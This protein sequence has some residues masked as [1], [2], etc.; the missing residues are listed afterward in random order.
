M[1]GLVKWA[2][3]GG[4][5]IAVSSPAQ[6]QS[7]ADRVSAV[8]E[9]TAEFHFAVRAGVC[10]N[11]DEGVSIGRTRQIGRFEAG[12]DGWYCEPGPVRV[13]LRVE[14]GVVR[15]IR[16]TVGP[17]RRLARD[18][19]AT[20]LGVV[21]AAAAATYFL[22]LAR[23]A[24]SHVSDRAITP[25]VLADS[26][27]PWRELLAVARDTATRSHGTRSSA[28]FWLSR[29][30]DAKMSGHPNDFTAPDDYALSDDN[31]AR[32]SAVFAL[33]QLRNHEGI[34]PL[35]QVART[36]RD[37]VVRRQALFWLGQSGD[38][39][40]LELFEEVLSSN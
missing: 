10:G 36:N 25:A 24:D 14:N 23:T 8:R 32:K 13:W 11:G 6:A 26:V 27:Y 38:T 16:T 30:V 35:V 5:V 39:R 18:P 33:S 29:F 34:L 12:D 15:D 40:A 28:A 7:I 22:Q 3:A 9:G 4:V 17:S 21:P 31:E 20:D 1:H 37:A 2:L 19:S